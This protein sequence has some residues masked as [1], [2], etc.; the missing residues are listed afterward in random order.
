[1]KRTPALTKKLMRPTSSGKSA[2][3]HFA[4]I[5]HRI[6]HG[7]GVGESEGKFL[8]RRR[9]RF[10]QMVGADIGRVPFRHFARGI[11]DHVLDQPQGRRR[12]EH[13][14]AARQILLQNVVLHGAG[15]LRLVRALLFGERGIEGEQPGR[16]GVDRHRGVHLGKRDAL[17]Q[18]AHVAEMGDGHAD[19]A[20]LAAGKR[21]IG[22]VAG[23]G[24]QVEGDRKPRLTLG[25]VLP[26]ERV[27]GL[28]RGMAGI[29]AEQPGL[30]P[31]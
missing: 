4:R 19:F 3:R 9:A 14:G 23:L 11:D 15:E 27:R 28:G 13:I 30:V 12:R 22:V 7:L 21:V 25:K 16:R 20:D 6:E 29:G 26:V 2:A 18:R 31:L 8:R 10:L 1:M 17:E 24:R 5:L